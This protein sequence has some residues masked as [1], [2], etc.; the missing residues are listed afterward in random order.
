MRLPRRRRPAGAGARS[1]ARVSGPAA[2]PRDKRATSRRPAGT[3][4][5]NRPSTRHSRTQ[6]TTE[7]DR[8]APAVAPPRRSGRLTSRAAILGLVVCAVV[9]TLAYPTR[10]YLAQRGQMAQLQAASH[11]KQ[12]KVDALKQQQRRWN[13]PS[14]VKAQARE[15]LQYVLPGQVLYVVVDPSRAKA[16]QQRPHATA[17]KPAP[18][19]RHQPWYTQLWG[20]ARA[21]DGA[22]AT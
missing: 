19:A 16:A 8:T 18:S 9:L 13:D 11:D 21:A 3:G 17:V 10:Q 14:Y 4:K 7:P 2:R 15:R 5:G 22:P 20:T 12:V 6:R 1:A